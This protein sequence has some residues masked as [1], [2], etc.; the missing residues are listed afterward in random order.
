[1]IV[2]STVALAHSLELPVIAEGIEHP[3][4]LSGLRT[5]GCE[6]GQGTCSQ[7]PAGD[8]DVRAWLEQWDPLQVVGLGARV[9]G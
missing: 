6:Y 1:M 7:H 3:D 8:E 9:D 5:L 4:Q 2:R